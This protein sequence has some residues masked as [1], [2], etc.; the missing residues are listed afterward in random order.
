MPTS[1]NPAGTA[2]RFCRL[3]VPPVGRALQGTVRRERY[4]GED[5]LEADPLHAGR[6]RAA[7]SWREHRQTADPGGLRRAFVRPPR[8]EGPVR[9]SGL[10][11]QTTHTPHSRSNDALQ[12]AGAG[13]F[14][15]GQGQT[16]IVEDDQRV[17]QHR[18]T[19]SISFRSTTDL[20]P[21]KAAEEG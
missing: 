6:H 7:L 16:S 12:G 11:A 17:R 5:A 9:R 8:D 15:G 18:R 21:P 1:R 2:V 3:A 20:S 19:G 4:G 13:P 10:E 14:H